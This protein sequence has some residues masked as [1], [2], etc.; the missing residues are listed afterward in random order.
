MVGVLI[1]AHGPFAEALISSAAHVMGKHPLNVTGI[2]VSTQDKPDPVL[3]RARRA[4]AQ[5]DGGQGVVVLTDMVGGT[6]SNIATRLLSDAHVAGLA[7]ANLP[8]LVRLLTYRN[9]GLDRAVQ[10]ALLGGSEGVALLAQEVG[11]AASR[12]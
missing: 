6:P 10:K 4:V 9:E 2:A 12:G 7:G 8:M 3:E 11:N 5:L 1:I